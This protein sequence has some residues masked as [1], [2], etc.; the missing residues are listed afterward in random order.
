MGWDVCGGCMQGT[1]RLT[2]GERFPIIAHIALLINPPWG[3]EDSHSGPEPFHTKQF[4]TDS[5]VLIRSDAVPPAPPRSGLLRCLQLPTLVFAAVRPGD[6]PVLPPYPTCLACLRERMDAELRT[7]AYPTPP[8][9][10]RSLD[11]GSVKP[12]SASKGIP[13]FSR[14]GPC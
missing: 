3:N 14:C 11:L 8:L 7:A 5:A 13:Y 4:R 6:D 2:V 12:R 10:Y 9:P 1:G